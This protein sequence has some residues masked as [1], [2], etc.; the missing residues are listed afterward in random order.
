MSLHN[1]DMAARIAAFD[2]PSH[3]LGPMESW[4]PTLHTMLRLCLDAANPTALYWGQDLRLLYNDAWA[5]IAGP[6]HPQ[7]LGQTMAEVWPD[8][9][10]VIEPQMRGVMQSGQGFC[11]ADQLLPM[12]RHGYV[13]ETYW[14]Y[15]FTPI[16][17]ETDAIVGIFNHGADVTERVF[18]SRRHTLLIGMGRRLRDCT[19]VA[20]MLDVALP[21]LADHLG[22]SR[23]V[24]GEVD[25]ERDVVV[26]RSSWTDGTLPDL[27][28][29]HRL[30]DL[31]TRIHDALANGTVYRLDNPGT[32]APGSPP[33]I[34]A[35]T[36]GSLLIAPLF[37]DG[38]HS[39]LLA[40]RH[41]V[42][43]H[44]SPYIDR[45][46]LDAGDLIHRE[47]S[48]VRAAIGLRD[49]EEKYRLI[50]DQAQ[51]FI[52][53]ADLDQRVTAVNRAVSDA[54]GIDGAA[55]IGRSLA[56]FLTPEDFARSSSMLAQ[57]L[58]QGGTTRYEVDV[59]MPHG[60]TARWEINS[61][62][63]TDRDGRAIG[64]HAIGRDVTARRAF[65]ERQALLI[66][67]LNHRVKNT[68]ALVQGLAAQ[69]FRGDRTMPDARAIF[70]G[71]L[72]RLAAA[73]DLLVREKWEGA[74]LGHL[75]GDATR[76]HAD[77]PDRLTISGPPVTLN[78]K[79]AIS[80]V[81]AF[82]ELATNAAK[83]GA[84]SVN[85]GSVAIDWTIDG[86]RLRIRWVESGGP[87]VAPPGRRGFGLRMIERALANDLDGTVTLDFREDGLVCLIDA[88]LPEPDAALAL[89]EEID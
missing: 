38:V 6:R 54:I 39:A 65:E 26:I 79:A 81:L 40:V 21:M 34:P 46:L 47:I 11:V 80:I 19:S 53:T 16:R 57:K 4:P 36:G 8:I 14:D 89:P 3:P 25:R 74:L 87:S 63:S 27:L 45:L 50:F 41:P 10:P 71:R 66:H 23:V 42:P 52:F 22:A 61:A 2:W 69:S 31:H 83:Y 85:G 78:P 62:L 56:D 75:I 72:G 59:A 77:P 33:A 1:G 12:A 35:E 84:L 88:P 86:E 73:H 44:F 29:E 70:E 82:H 24:Y 13:E 7:A 67:E 28:G 60:G 17:D 49:S 9:W 30:G 37:L 43:R 18:A 76:A 68:L 20:E 58:T 15:V 5:P 32:A 51:D 64:L 48:R 55:L